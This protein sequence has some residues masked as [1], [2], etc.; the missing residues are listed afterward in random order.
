M[1][2][3]FANFLHESGNFTAGREWAGWFELVHV[4]DNERVREIHPARLHLDQNLVLAA[5]RH[6][7]VFDHQSI[8]SAY[9]LGEHCFHACNFLPV[10]LFLLPDGSGVPNKSPSLT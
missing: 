8:R 5:F 2:D 4:L 9:F 10:L 7:G 1:A 3:A 6:R